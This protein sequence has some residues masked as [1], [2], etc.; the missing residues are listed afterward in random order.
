MDV[1][2]LGANCSGLNASTPLTPFADGRI[3]HFI[4]ADTIVFSEKAFSLALMYSPT[5]SSFRMGRPV[6]ARWRS[7]YF[8]HAF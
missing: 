3:L 7:S 1:S 8:A 4:H 6:S 5:T 2:L